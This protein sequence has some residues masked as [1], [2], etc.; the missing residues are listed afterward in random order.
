MNVPMAGEQQR[1]TGDSP[2]KGNL[3]GQICEWCRE[4]T[5]A[6]VALPV[7]RKIKGGKAGAVVDT[8]TFIY[9]CREHEDIG[10]RSNPTRSSLR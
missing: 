7:R 9:T 8:G 2:G 3:E 5:P 4:P 1:I 6:T 10:R